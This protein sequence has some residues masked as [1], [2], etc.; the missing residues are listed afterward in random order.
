MTIRR[1]FIKI[2]MEGISWQIK[3]TKST[4]KDLLEIVEDI[5]KLFDSEVKEKKK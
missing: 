1:V 4:K 2:R 5:N 3:A